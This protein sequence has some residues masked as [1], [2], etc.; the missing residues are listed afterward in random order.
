MAPYWQILFIENEKNIGLC[1]FETI[2]T[3]HKAHFAIKIIF[4]LYPPEMSNLFV[5]FFFRN[6]ILVDPN[7][8]VLLIPNINTI[9]IVPN[10]TLYFLLRSFRKFISATRWRQG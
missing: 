3:F 7:V 2:K 8:L 5:L 4:I 1:N 9:F 10:I 6:I